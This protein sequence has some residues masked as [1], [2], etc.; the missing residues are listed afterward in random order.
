MILAYCGGSV[1]L[2]MLMII[3]CLSVALCKVKIHQ[4]N[5]PPTQVTT[6]TGEQVYDEITL[7]RVFPDIDTQANVSYV[8]HKKTAST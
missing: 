3:T 4:Q 6:V 5:R 7:A 2:V 1:L 8:T